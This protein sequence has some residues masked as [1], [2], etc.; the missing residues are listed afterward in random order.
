[1]NIEFFLLVSWFI[2]LSLVIYIASESCNIY[3]TGIIIEMN[4]VDRYS[5]HGFKHTF[6]EFTVQVKNKKYITEV[7]QET[8]SQYSINNKFSIKC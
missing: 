2:T 8:Y 1:M 3:R 6:H 4:I 7:S 5:L